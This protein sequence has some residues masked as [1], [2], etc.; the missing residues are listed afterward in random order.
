MPWAPQCAR[1]PCAGRCD[2][3]RHRSHYLRQT[4]PVGQHRLPRGAGI[5][6]APDVR[7]G[8]SCRQ[9]SLRQLMQGSL[10]REAHSASAR[11]TSG[12]GGTGDPAGT[13]RERRLRCRRRIWSVQA[14]LAVSDGSCAEV[15]AWCRRH[16]CRSDAPAGAVAAAGGA[17]RGWAI[18]GCWPLDGQSTCKAPAVGRLRGS[19]GGRRRSHRGTALQQC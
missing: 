2:G 13:P 16:L 14:Q 9:R 5:G 18:D 12:C 7:C 11:C 3:S 8:R 15:G 10:R 6:A 1:I 19:G 4:G 17:G